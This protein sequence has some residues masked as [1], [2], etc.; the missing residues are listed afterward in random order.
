MARELVTARE[1]EGIFETVQ[2]MRMNG[3]RRMPVIDGHG[4][5][6]G[7]VS[8]DDLIQLLA[9]EMGALAKLIS[10]GQVREAWIKA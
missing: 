10:R 7:V 5:L 8:V 6:V 2:R 9:E 1:N 4:A 3:V